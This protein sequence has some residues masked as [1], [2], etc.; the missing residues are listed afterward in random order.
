MGRV[1]TA[2]QYPTPPSPIWPET[3]LYGTP[4]P[5]RPRR[6]WP[7]EILAGLLVVLTI[8]TLGAPLGVLWSALA[9]R[10]LFQMTADGLFYTDAEPEEYVG[11]DVV[12]TLIG[13]G[14]GILLGLACWLLLRR[15]RGAFVLVGLM[16]GS[17][18][19]ACL[20][21]QIGR[22]IGLDDY[23]SL[24]TTAHV[25][26]QFYRPASMNSGEFL[27]I[28]DVPVFPRGALAAQALAAVFT[29]TMI[30]GWSR[31][32]GLRPGSD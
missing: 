17:L 29:Y 15:W 9:P 26:W 20:A 13:L 18:L 5:P 27:R 23:L 19:G 6:D 16:V 12:F 28:L 7:R 14:A 8:A 1:S 3:G 21:W 11:A 2:E 10:V 25:G 30:A 31:F 4:V 22:R 24:K 32:P